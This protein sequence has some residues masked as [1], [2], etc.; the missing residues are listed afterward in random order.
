MAATRRCTLALISAAPCLLPL[1]Q[2]YWADNTRAYRYVTSQTIRNTFW[3]VGLQATVNLP[4]GLSSL[5]CIRPAS[6]C[7]A[8][9]GFLVFRLLLMPR[10]YPALLPTERGQRVAAPAAGGAARG[11]PHGG[12]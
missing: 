5:P 8:W 10:C 3:Q 6:V 7:D 4:Q 11:R 12:G 2:K 1:L 9:P